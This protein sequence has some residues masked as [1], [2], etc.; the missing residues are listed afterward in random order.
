MFVREAGSD[1]RLKSWFFHL[2]LIC[3]IQKQRSIMEKTELIYLTTQH[4]CT[5]SSYHPVVL[6]QNSHS[7]LQTQLIGFFC[8]T[9]CYNRWIYEWEALH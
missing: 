6:A 8:D 1:S 3:F 5:C 2:G 4:L 7:F 9:P